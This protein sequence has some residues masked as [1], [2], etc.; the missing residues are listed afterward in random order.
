MD[1]VHAHFAISTCE[2]LEL[3]NGVVVDAHQLFARGVH[4]KC[5]WPVGETIG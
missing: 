2:H 4:E 5:L 1:V 3:V